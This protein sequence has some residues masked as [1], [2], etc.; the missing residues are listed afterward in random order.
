MKLLYTFCLLFL[1]AINSE[2]QNHPATA[3]YDLKKKRLLIC[4]I[5]IKDQ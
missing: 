3:G 1:I 5:Q 2:A 4:I